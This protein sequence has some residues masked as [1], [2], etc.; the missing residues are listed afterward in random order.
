TLIWFEAS[1]RLVAS[2]QDLAHCLGPRPATVARELTKQFEEARRGSL[3]ELCSHYAEAGA[4]RG[5]IAIVVGPPT[6]GKD[7][8]ADDTLDDQLAKALLTM[9]PSAAAS[10]VASATGRA[11]RGLYKRALALRADQGTPDPSAG[12]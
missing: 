6:S 2:L 9:S 8:I 7:A 12:A 11:K 5:E 10:S 3:V 4:P 1:Q